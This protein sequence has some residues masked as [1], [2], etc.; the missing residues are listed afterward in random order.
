MAM[1]KSKLEISVQFIQKFKLT[2]DLAGLEK[3]VKD[4]CLEFSK[5]QIK[6]TLYEINIQIIGD[7]EIK[8]I[9][10]KFLNKN[11]VTDCISFDLSDNST[12]IKSFDLA[13][14][15][16]K[17]VKEAKKRGHSIHAELALYITHGLLHNF[18]FNDAKPQDAE[19][20]HN[21]EDKI[22][23]EHSFGLVYNSIKENR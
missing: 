14:N 13:V 9:N 12:S 2:V 1:E 10:K 3:L 7:S 19:K 6:K 11:T 20:M 15:A 17:A 18:G 5:K 22:L 16:Q 8:K 21:T 4:I 23:N